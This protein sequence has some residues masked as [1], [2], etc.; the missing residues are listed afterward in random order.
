MEPQA[1]FLPSQAFSNIRWLGNQINY[2]YDYSVKSYKCQW[3]GTG[4]LKNIDVTRFMVVSV[5]NSKTIVMVP[6]SVFSLVVVF[7]SAVV[8]VLISGL[9]AV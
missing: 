8:A 4:K 9:D 3:D 7:C 1:V 2:V 5:F 6:L